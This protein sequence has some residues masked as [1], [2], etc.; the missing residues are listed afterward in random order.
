MKNRLL[1]IIAAFSLV[2]YIFMTAAA[3][4]LQEKEYKEP[5][6]SL[7]SQEM[8][9]EPSHIITSG[10]DEDVPYL[11][12]LGKIGFEVSSLGVKQGGF[13]VMTA[14]NINPMEI[15]FSS[16]FN[17]TPVWVAVDDHF[18]ALIPVKFTYE[19]GEYLIE[20]STEERNEDFLITVTDGGFDTQ[21]LT[22]DES[23]TSST[24]DNSAAN[25]EYFKKAQPVKSISYSEIL[26]DEEFIMPAEGKMTTSFGSGRVVNGKPSDRHGGID[27][28]AER[29][30][31][32]KAS[33]S[34]EVIFAEFLQLT[35]NT[36]C[37]EHGMGLKTWYYHMDSLDVVSGERV[38]KGETIGTIGST[39]FST[40]P[41]L[42][43]AVAVGTVYVDPALVIDT[44]LPLV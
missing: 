29:G 5:K 12:T 39:G 40:G 21:Y 38:S 42:H 15:K 26:W 32:V 34:G 9:D 13:I 25:D 27:I 10:P 31:P 19:P 3:I 16:P 22:V 20:V 6:S 41:H 33:N 7:P 37:I 44:K 36:V 24:I 43:F 2:T 30:T 17:I 14:H 18:S 23:V 28:A 11:D 35:G 8:A 4:A 1:R